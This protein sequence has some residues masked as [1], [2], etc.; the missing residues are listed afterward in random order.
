[1]LIQ[2]WATLYNAGLT[3][4]Q[5]GVNISRLLGAQQTRGIHPMLFQFWP[6]V[7]DA[8]PTLRQHWVNA[9]CSLGGAVN[10]VNTRVPMCA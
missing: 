7:F 8:G 1:M 6:T 2:C 3:L 9:S 10:Q 4:S 5:H